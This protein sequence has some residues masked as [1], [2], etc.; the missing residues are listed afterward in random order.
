MAN[1]SP[2]SV[3][4]H[5]Y[6]LI[7]GFQFSTKDFYAQVAQKVQ[8]R[9]V[10]EAN[11]YEVTFHEGTIL[12]AKRAYLRVQ[13]KA[14]MFDL[15]AA[16]FGR[17]FFVSWWLGEPFGCLYATLAPLPFIGP[18]IAQFMRPVTYYSADTA[19]MFQEAVHASVLEVVDAITKDKG[20]RALTELE[21]KPILRGFLDR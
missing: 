20:I 15:C 6:H 11:S 18:A 10:P 14:L 8:E 12:S 2:A 17:G 9:S 1:P 7:D 16:P 19:L 13:R 21:R 5:W 3:Y 4:S